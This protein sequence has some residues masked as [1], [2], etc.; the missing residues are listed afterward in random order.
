[1]SVAL[2]SPLVDFGWD[3]VFARAFALVEEPGREP[4]RIVAEHRGSY[5]VVTV[6]GERSAQLAGRLRYDANGRPDLPVVGDWVVVDGPAIVAILDRRTV[7]TRRDP[8]PRIGEQLLC[9]N[10]DV[11]FLVT[12][13]NRDLNL[14]RLERYLAM[15]WSSGASPV[16]LLSK[17]DIAPD[18]DAAVESVE[19]I[20]GD[21]P[22]AAVSAVSGVGLD[23]VRAFLSAGR[24]SVFLGSSGVGKSTLLNAL[25]GREIAL[26]GEI[27][28]DDARG[29]HTTTTR[30][31]VT[32]PDGWLVIDTPGLRELGLADVDGGAGLERTF[33][34]VETIAAECRFSDCR[35][36]REP[37]CAVRAALADGRLDHA[38][39]E[40]HRKLER[41]LARAARTV[42]PAAR[43]EHRAKWRAI[44]RAVNEHMERK[45][46][47]DR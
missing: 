16:V 29:R 26:T 30:Q 11:A 13:A 22:V 9:A 47:A 12:S 2:T 36:E 32:L 24:T 14:R 44:H 46:G 28:A 27:R 42:N 35:H 20:A 40:S 33:A 17:A 3:P 8:D 41:E 1:M 10:V 37:G 39:L 23:D 19:R 21:V 38:R 6:D 31:L 25:A 18:L 5:R 45:Y 34:D 4:G 7:F 43:A 15:A